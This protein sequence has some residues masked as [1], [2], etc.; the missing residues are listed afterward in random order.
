MKFEQLLRGLKLARPPAGTMPLAGGELRFTGDKDLAS[1]RTVRIVDG[2]GTVTRAW[3]GYGDPLAWPGISM[4]SSGQLFVMR[5]D[6]HTYRVSGEQ[7]RIASSTPV[8]ARLPE[9]PRYELARRLE[10]GQT[11]IEPRGWQR[12]HWFELRAS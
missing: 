11:V 1:I 9:F 6:S 7:V 12:G 2:A 8:S 3:S 5:I 10:H 4:S